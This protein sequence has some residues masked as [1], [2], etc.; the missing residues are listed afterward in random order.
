MESRQ[1]DA[2]Q[3]AGTAK[4]FYVIGDARKPANIYRSVRSAFGI[5]S[6]I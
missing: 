5:A 3:Y 4:E 1:A 6:M 2:L